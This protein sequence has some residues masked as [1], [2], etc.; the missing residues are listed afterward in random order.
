MCEPQSVDGKMKKKQQFCGVI[1]ALK[2]GTL[3]DILVT[4]IFLEISS[5]W[6]LTF[7]HIFLRT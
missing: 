7:F 1:A 3:Q 4:R 6:R 2:K 5:T